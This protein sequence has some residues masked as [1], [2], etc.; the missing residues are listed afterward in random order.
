MSFPNNVNL[1]PGMEKVTNTVKK[2][3]LG[4]H[5]SNNFG[6]VF[7]YAFAGEAIGAGQV[8][9]GKVY[10][11]GH[12]QDLVPVTAGAVGDLTMDMTMITTATTL[13]QY[14]DG[15]IFVNDG[16]G[17]G[18]K[19]RIKSNPAAGAT[20]TLVV[21]LYD[22]DPLAEAT[23]VSASS[24]FGLQENVYKDVEIF[25][26][27][28]VDGSPLGV[29]PTEVANNAYFWIQKLGLVCVNNDSG[30]TVISGDALQASQTTNGSV[31]LADTSGDNDSYIIGVAVQ[32]A[33][34][35]SDSLLAMINCP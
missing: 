6:E 23:V 35:A 28:D 10:T 20:D 32:V 27:D 16:A 22:N 26:Q 7:V 15:V 13:N 25:D 33:P 12:E 2:H 4:T 17:E 3:N 30:T 29:A 21:T 18:H 31:E 24:L 5:A 19:Y 9:M 34:A 11:A 1:S 14:E 8:V